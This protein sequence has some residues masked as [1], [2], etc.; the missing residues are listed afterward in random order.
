MRELTEMELKG[1]IGIRQNELRKLE[2]M[3][4]IED[5]A[6][7]LDKIDGQMAMIQREIETYQK[8][9]ERYQ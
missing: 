3:L 7:H 6:I 9:L 1:L 4:D 8:M 2:G 5:D